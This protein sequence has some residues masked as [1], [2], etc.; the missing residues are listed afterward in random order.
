MRT[1][2]SLPFNLDVLSASLLKNASFVSGHRFSDAES[3][4]R[5]GYPFRG[6]PSQ[7]EFFS[8]LLRARQPQLLGNR[9]HGFDA[10]RN[11]LFEVHAEIGGSS[12]DV[13]PMY[14]AGKGFVLHFFPDRLGLDFGER[15]SRLDQRA[16]GEKSGEFIARK[17]R[18][19]QG[20]DARDSRVLGM[21]QDGAP[22][23]FGVAAFFQNPRSFVGMFLGAGIF[24]VIEVME[25]ADHA[26][27]FLVASALAGIGAHASLYRERMF[28]KTLR[29]RELS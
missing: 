2:A 19:F 8:K 28:S 5:F 9:L 1:V 11:I 13:F 4:L 22:H 17:K 21:R 16:G 29:L 18:F 3:A 6:W 24:L 15:F 12:D 26:P 10:E 14:A 27:Q 20:G 25:K 7:T 23:F